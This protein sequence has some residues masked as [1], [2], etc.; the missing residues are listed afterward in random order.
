LARRLFG[1]RR[2]LRGDLTCYLG[3]FR[4]GALAGPRVDRSPGRSLGDSLGV[5]LGDFHV[6]SPGAARWFEAGLSS[7]GSGG[8]RRAR[9]AHKRQRQETHRRRRRAMRL[10]VILLG[11]TAISHTVSTHSPSR[12]FTPQLH[13]ATHSPIHL[14]PTSIPPLHYPH[15]LPPSCFPPHSELP[16]HPPRPRPR[17]PFLCSLFFHLSLR[18]PYVLYHTFVLPLCPHLHLPTCHPLLFPPFRPTYSYSRTLYSRN[19]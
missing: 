15:H 11:R 19:W 13:S 2:L 7:A 14:L 9:S 10:A 1:F 12:F 17:I 8:N 6:D 16:P 3:E 5:S 18:T 4:R